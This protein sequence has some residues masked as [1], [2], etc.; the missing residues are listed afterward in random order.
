MKEDYVGTNKDGEKVT[1]KAHGGP[2]DIEGIAVAVVNDRLQLQK[3]E[4]FFDPMMMFRQMEK[5]V[6]A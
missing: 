2:I 5:K 1:L 3:V 6:N 4:V